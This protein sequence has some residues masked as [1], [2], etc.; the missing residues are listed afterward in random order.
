[1]GAGIGGLSTAGALSD[2][3]EQVEIFERD[4]SSTFVGSRLGTPQDRH[5]HALLAGGLRALGALFPAF[6]DDLAKAGAVSLGMSR[7]VHFERPDVGLLPKRDLGIALLRASR[8]LIEFVLRNRGAASPA[9]MQTPSDAP[10]DYQLA[11]TLPDPPNL[12][13][14]AVLLPIEGN[15]WITLIADRGA[16]TRLDSWDPFVGASRSLI[17]PHVIA[18]SPFPDPASQSSTSWEGRVLCSRS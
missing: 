2:C 4:R 8:P 9:V 14:D 12:A 6:E 15:R 1:M 3:F 16:T 18:A 5:P 17:T 11:L 7:D 13:R 10:T